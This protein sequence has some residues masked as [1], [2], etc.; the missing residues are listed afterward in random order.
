MFADECRELLV[1]WAVEEPV[2]GLSVVTVYHC[3]RVTPKGANKGSLFDSLAEVDEMYVRANGI[4]ARQWLP[5]G[6]IMPEAWGV[7]IPL[8][9]QLRIFRQPRNALLAVLYAIRDLR[10][11]RAKAAVAL[12]R[13]LEEETLPLL[14]TVICP[15]RFRLLNETAGP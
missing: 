12:G 13:R 6:L 8:R 15:P 9:D 2:T 10:T 1:K 4:R 3:H 7:M 5:W 14:E 11:A